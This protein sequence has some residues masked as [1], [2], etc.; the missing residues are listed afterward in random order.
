MEPE[1]I[2]TEIALKNNVLFT[3]H[4]PCT[5]GKTSPCD[6]PQCQHADQLNRGEINCEYC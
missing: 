6:C 5:D 4:G 1:Y 2:F 3:V